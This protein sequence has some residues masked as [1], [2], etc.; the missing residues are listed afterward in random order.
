[1]TGF[2][3]KKR[4]SGLNPLSNENSRA[5]H[6]D[7]K[8]Q[9]VAVGFT[10]QDAPQSVNDSVKLIT[11]TVRSLSLSKLEGNVLSAQSSEVLK[12]SDHT[13]KPPAI[14]NPLLTN[15][16]GN[17]PSFLR[18]SGSS[19]KGGAISAFRGSEQFNNQAP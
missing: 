6:L 14:F 11:D 3:V 8:Q 16:Y 17:F 1:M 18:S 9:R 10:P 12:N 13:T 19:G 5:P 15:E 2:A 4:D 7:D